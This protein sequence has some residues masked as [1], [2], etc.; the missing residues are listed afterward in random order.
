MHLPTP[1]RQAIA[2]AAGIIVGAT[3]VM[4]YEFA[5]DAL[6]F[7]RTGQRSILSDPAAGPVASASDNASA[8]FFFSLYYGCLIAAVCVPLWLILLRYERTGT[9]AAAVLGF[10][11]TLCVWVVADY[12]ALN[13]IAG[14][15]P[16]ALCGAIAGLAIWWTERGLAKTLA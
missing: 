2:V 10:T 3:A 16:Y 13:S 8:A 9:A 15:I 4:L 5:H 14:G 7:V 12:P 6:L 11:A 1:A